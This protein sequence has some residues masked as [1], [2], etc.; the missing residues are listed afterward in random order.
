MVARTFAALALAACAEPNPE[1][2]DAPC[3]PWDKPPQTANE[4]LLL[5]DS[6]IPMLVY[7]GDGM[8]GC[9]PSGDLAVVCPDLDDHWCTCHQAGS[10]WRCSW[11]GP[12]DWWALV[13]QADFGG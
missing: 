7:P 6:R 9:W 10:E 1:A 5:P 11:S 3:A 4:G 13:Q 12:D 8:V 2:E